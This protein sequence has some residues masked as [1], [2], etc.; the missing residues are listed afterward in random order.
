M[1]LTP[2]GMSPLCGEECLHNDV[3]VTQED[4]REHREM[5][6]EDHADGFSGADSKPDAHAYWALATGTMGLQAARVGLRSP[7][8]RACSSAAWVISRS[9]N[10][11]RKLHP[12]PRR[13]VAPNGLFTLAWA[14]C[15]EY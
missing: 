3:L 15:C 10:S 6:T 9:H 5:Y 1:F 4:E 8:L 2:S 13:T 14:T 11:P 12:I 7:A